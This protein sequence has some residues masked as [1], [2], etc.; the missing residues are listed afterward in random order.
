MNTT[1]L[2]PDVLQQ[3]RD[4]HAAPPPGFWPP[5]PGWWLLAAVLVAL[6]YGLVR[7]GLR[8]HRCRR[9]WKAA[10]AELQQYRQQWRQQG[11]ERALLAHVSALLRRVARHGFDTETAARSGNAWLEWLDQGLP[12]PEQGF[13]RGPGRV[14]ADGLYRPQVELDGDALLQLVERWLRHQMRR[15]GRC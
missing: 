13:S 9:L 2:P 3:L 8:R 7:Y 5:A 6:G 14:L 4:I 15:R 11:D 10:L 1:P 12:N